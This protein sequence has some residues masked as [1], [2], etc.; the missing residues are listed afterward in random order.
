MSCS[1]PPSTARSKENC[2]STSKLKLPTEYKSHPVKTNSTIR[3]FVLPVL[4]VAQGCYSPTREIPLNTVS[5]PDVSLPNPSSKRDGTLSVQVTDTRAEKPKIGKMSGRIGANAIFVISGG[6]EPRMAEILKEALERAG[7]SVTPTAQA[8][9]EAEILEFKVYSNGWTQGAKETIRFL[10]RD[11]DGGVLWERTVKGEDGGMDL[12]DSFAEK[13]MNVAL[14]RLLTN[15]IQQFTSE[16]FYQAVQ[17][18]P[19]EK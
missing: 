11:K 12:V 5:F 10:V 1:P 7:Y 18:S 19:G 15:A 14:T 4:L 16:S 6:L 9:L 8:K 17:K 13:S 2:E 3:L